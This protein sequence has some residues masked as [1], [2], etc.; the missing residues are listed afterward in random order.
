AEGY[1]VWVALED[2]S[3]FLRAEAQS[4]SFNLSF[5]ESRWDTLKLKGPRFETLRLVIGVMTPEG[6]IIGKLYSTFFTTS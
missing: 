5:K 1:R 6:E 4:A 3:G 2:Q